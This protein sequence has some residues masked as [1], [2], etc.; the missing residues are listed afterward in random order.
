M[1]EKVSSASV[2]SR[3]PQTRNLSRKCGR[4]PFERDN[5]PDA[6]FA[7]TWK[8]SLPGTLHPGPETPGREALERSLKRS[9]SGRQANRETHATCNHMG[10]TGSVAI[11]GFRHKGLHRFFATG[12]KSGIQAKHAARLRLIL[13]RLNVATSTQ[14]MD[15]PGLDL[16]VLRG[17]RKGTWAVK[18]SRNWRVTFTFVGRDV[19]RVDY[20]DYH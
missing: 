2:I 8:E 15:L 5:H 19:D 7:I 17:L 10:Y 16:H 3:A 9:G 20:E 18:V 1:S 4:S 11:T 6:W 14:D 12:A 13:G